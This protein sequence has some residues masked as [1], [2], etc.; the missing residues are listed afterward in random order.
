MSEMTKPDSRIID[1]S[2]YQKKKIYNEFHAIVY[3]EFN[4]SISDI[5]NFFGYD[6][7]HLFEIL[8]EVYDEGG[9]IKMREEIGYTIESFKLEFGLKKTTC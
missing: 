6:S 3:K 9:P 7:D 2:I 4:K 1:F 5:N 8:E